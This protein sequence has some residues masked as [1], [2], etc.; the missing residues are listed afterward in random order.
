MKI[1]ARKVQG[2]EGFYLVWSDGRVRSVPN[3]FR[4]VSLLLED[5][6]DAY[7]YVHNRYSGNTGTHFLHRH[8][9]VAI[10]FIPNPK[11]HPVVYHLNGDKQD[12]RVE[13][14]AWG[15]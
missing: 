10:A 11:G 8:T 3:R 15:E 6:L 1:W 4:P 12:N 7:G 9:V 13:N 2:Y 5:S 14:L